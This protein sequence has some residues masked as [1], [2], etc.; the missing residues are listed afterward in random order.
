MKAF[1]QA[2]AKN[3]GS[4][5]TKDAEEGEVT[6]NSMGIHT[7]RSA[8]HLAAQIGDSGSQHYWKCA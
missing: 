7:A 4:F 6:G 1:E 5:A 2:H 8:V 3:H